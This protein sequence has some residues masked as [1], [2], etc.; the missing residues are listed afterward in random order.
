MKLLPIKEHLHENQEFAANPDTSDSLG[1]CVDF[2]KKIGYNPPWIC[3]YAEKDGNLVGG[4]TRS[5]SERGRS[6]RTAS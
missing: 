3:Y 5:A 2:Y 6:R 4:A 1:A